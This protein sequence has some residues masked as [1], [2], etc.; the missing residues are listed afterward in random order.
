MPIEP[1][2]LVQQLF[3]DVV[4]RGRLEL[5]DQLIAPDIRFHTPVPGLPQSRDGF[6]SFLRLYLEAFPDQL[7]TVDQ[8]LVDGRYVVVRHTH[9][10]RHTGPFLGM[11]PTGR[12]AT[13]AGVE[14][15]RI[16]DDRIAEFWH[17]DDIF[18]LVTQ[19]GL[20]VPRANADGAA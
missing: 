18:S 16:Q 3:S 12:E 20:F 8:L 17:Y 1:K 15:F 13:V 4:N 14:I 2:S 6:R 5:L 19:L 10:V 11:P 9:K 7:T